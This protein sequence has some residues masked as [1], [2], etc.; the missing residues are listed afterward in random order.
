MN[1]KRPSN[2]VDLYAGCRFRMTVGGR[3][4]VPVR[5]T[6]VRHK[7]SYSE[8]LRSG[9][10]GIADASFVASGSCDSLDCPGD[11][12]VGPRTIN[13]TVE[14][15]GT[16]SVPQPHACLLIECRDIRGT[17][18]ILAGVWRPIIVEGC[19]LHAYRELCRLDIGEAG[20]TPSRFQFAR[21]G[22]RPGE[23]ARTEQ[24][25]GGIQYS[26]GIVSVI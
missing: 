26:R 6:G 17:R 16:D 20:L 25:S 4:L 18:P 9:H 12:H 1:G 19:E 22:H 2:A 5:L 23:A 8:R 7:R 13:V 10:S 14:I 24:S 11:R 15:S 21:P 3:S